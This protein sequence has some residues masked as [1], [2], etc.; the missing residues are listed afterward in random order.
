MGW[1]Y[2]FIVFSPTKH[3]KGF[4]TVKVQDNKRNGR[5]AISRYEVTKY[6]QGTPP[7]RRTLT[8]E[9][10]AEDTSE[11]EEE[12]QAAKSDSRKILDLRVSG[13]NG[14]QDKWRVI[15]YLYTKQMTQNNISVRKYN[16]QTA[17]YRA[18]TVPLVLGERLLPSW[19]LGATTPRVSQEG[20]VY[21]DVRV[22]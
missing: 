3:T 22:L 20:E 7:V 17:K 15:K 12:S 18:V 2:A 11:A 5:H 6:F 14:C 21:T 10:A 19:H 13:M 8:D 16:S 4:F 9:A 1:A